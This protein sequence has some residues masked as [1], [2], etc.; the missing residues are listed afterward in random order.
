MYK[1]SIEY[2]LIKGIL[3]LKNTLL[4]ILITILFLSISQ[5]YSQSILVA[6]GSS[7]IDDQTIEMRNEILCTGNQPINIRIDGVYGG[8]YTA[9]VLWY[10]SHKDKQTGSYLSGD[11]RIRFVNNNERDS[12]FS[13]LARRFFLTHE[14]LKK[15]EIYK[16]K[17]LNKK[18]IKKKQE[19][20]ID[21]SF[22]H[23]FS[24]FNKTRSPVPPPFFFEDINFDGSEE[25]IVVEYMNGQRWRDLYKV[26]NFVNGNFDNIYDL[27]EQ[28]PYRLLDSMTEFD[29]A[30]RTITIMNSG[31]S[32]YTNYREY[33]LKN[34][35]YILNKLTV[36]SDYDFNDQ[37][38]PCTQFM[39]NASYNSLLSEY[40]YSLL[41]KQLI[42]KFDN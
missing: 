40:T 15:L 34:N 12:S 13:I 21:Y 20:V 32:C 7:G 5:V 37:R 16:D 41:H 38:I 11:A 23:E 36:I 26:Y 9:Y 31:G 18:A 1:L 30:N 8:Q 14:A 35:R 2:Y 28:A 24:L 22:F 6:E 4:P 10:P 33:K 39:Y 3:F 42:D 19:F 29:Y 27:T 17:K 25:L